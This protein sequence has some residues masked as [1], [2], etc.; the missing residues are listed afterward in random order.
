VNKQDALE[1]SQLQ[2]AF[3][4]KY[5]SMGID[6]DIL[7]EDLHEL[8][9]H[10]PHHQRAQILGSAIVIGNVGVAKDSAN[11]ALLDEALPEARV[12]AS[13]AAGLGNTPEAR[14]ILRGFLGLDR[15]ML[16]EFVSLDA[17]YPDQLGVSILSSQLHPVTSIFRKSGSLGERILDKEL[18]YIDLNVTLTKFEKCFLGS[19]LILTPDTNFVE[20]SSLVPGD[21]VLSFAPSGASSRTPL[22]PKKVVRTFANITEEWLRLSWTEDGEEKELVTTPSHQ[23]L[24]AHGGFCEI[25]SL[26]AGGKGTVVLADGSSTEVTS[27][28]IVYSAATADRFEQAE[29]YVYPENGNLALKPVYKKGW[30]TYNFRS[31]GLPYLCRRRRSG[32]Q[33]FLERRQRL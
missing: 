10:S 2:R 7:K 14:A 23:F 11:Q 3:L 19:T 8:G 31:R 13:M 30:K 12:I 21:L 18:E 28:R 24:S 16:T 4:E 1:L 6:N 22:S 5:G 20:I 33:R 26:V 29:G 32:S 25:D 17:R 27:E 9:S 15:P